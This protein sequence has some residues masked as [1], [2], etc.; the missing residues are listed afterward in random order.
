LHGALGG[1]ALESRRL[2]PMGKTVAQQLLAFP[3]PV[4][5]ATARRL[6]AGHERL[7][8]MSA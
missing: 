2:D 8:G 6:E 4:P 3:V 7:S 5:A 1:G